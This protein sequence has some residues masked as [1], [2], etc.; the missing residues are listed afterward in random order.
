MV[1]EV[2]QSISIYQL[3]GLAVL[4]WAC[5]KMV[6][7]FKKFIWGGPQQQKKWALISS[8]GLTRIKEEGGL[9]LRDPYLTN[10]IMGGKLGWRWMTGGGDLWKRI[11]MR[12][13]NMP[14]RVEDILR[15]VDPPRGSTIWN[16]ESQNRDIIKNHA[17]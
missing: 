2:L 1:K 11:W 7:I 15:Y 8:H 5:S 10:Q 6:E 4:K 3:S 12:K 13:Y 17:F 9:G 14:R 16:M